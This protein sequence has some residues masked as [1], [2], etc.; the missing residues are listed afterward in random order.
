MFRYQSDL[1]IGDIQIPPPY[2][3]SDISSV[4]YYLLISDLKASSMSNLYDSEDKP[5]FITKLFTTTSAIATSVA[6]NTNLG[7]ATAILKLNLQTV[8]TAGSEIASSLNGNFNL[9]ISQKLL[10]AALTDYIPEQ[11]ASKIPEKVK[12]MVDNFVQLGYLVVDKDDYVIAINRSGQTLNING[13][14]VADLPQFFA[15]ITQQVQSPAAVPSSPTNA[16]SENN[17]QAE[18]AC[19]TGQMNPEKIFNSS[20]MYGAGPGSKEVFSSTNQNPED[21]PKFKDFIKQC[22][23]YEAQAKQSDPNKAGAIGAMV[24]CFPAVA[25]QPEKDAPVCICQ[26]GKLDYQQKK[27]TNYFHYWA[28]QGF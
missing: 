9:R 2:H 5:N 7:A 6:M 17:F 14:P 18:Q 21:D 16:V 15:N 10:E 27:N 20:Y 8:P 1:S 11:D 24:T 19:S 23:A 3:V 22:I 25:G 13:K 28:C 12:T 26:A 4:K